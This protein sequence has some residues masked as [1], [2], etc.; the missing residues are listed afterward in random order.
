M[1]RDMSANYNITC[2]L[3]WPLVTHNPIFGDNSILER[4]HM[5]NQNLQEVHGQSH[6]T[7]NSLK[8]Y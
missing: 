2:H 6:V 5:H 8:K 3:Q 1:V 7:L 4:S